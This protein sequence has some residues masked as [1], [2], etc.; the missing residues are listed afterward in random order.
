MFVY[1]ITKE[2]TIY[3]VVIA[4]D[5]RWPCPVLASRKLCPCF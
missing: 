2:H 5:K 3:I 1:G 4:K